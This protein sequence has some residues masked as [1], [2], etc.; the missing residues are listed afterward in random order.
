M[1]S[2]SIVCMAD[3]II[4]RGAAD[5]PCLDTISWFNN[6]QPATDELPYITKVE[7]KR[8]RNGCHIDLGTQRRREESHV[9]LQS[10]FMAEFEN[11]RLA[12]TPIS[13]RPATSEIFRRAKAYMMSQGHRVTLSGLGGDSVTG[14]VVPTPTPELQNLLARARFFTLARQ[15][16]AWATKMRKSRLLLLWEAVRGF[17]LPALAG[18]PKDASLASW[19][20]TSFVR[21]NRTALRNYPSRVKLFGPLPS[22]QDHL[23]ALDG[24]RRLM[25]YCALSP[26]MLR[27]ARYPYLDRDFLEFMYAI[28]REQIVRVGQRRFLMKRALVGIVPDEVLHRRKKTFL[29]QELQKDNPTEC[30]TSAELGQHIVGS[31]IGIIDSNQLLE[32]VKKVRRNEEVPISCLMRT[33]TLESWLRHLAIQGV[34]TDSMSTKRQGHSSSLAMKELRTSAQPKSSVS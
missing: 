11:D 16:N 32:V 31:S 17:C 2:S 29:Q 1:D 10:S 6:S 28:P 34:L 19:L 30:P 3:V 14:G 18:M 9:R 22:F 7:E 5:C 23:E 21:R 8:G 15:L 24:E 13:N 12:A 33:L 4:A 25:E 26:E 20:N 27:E